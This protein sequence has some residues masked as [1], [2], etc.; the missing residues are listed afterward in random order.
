MI[1]DPQSTRP[2]SEQHAIGARDALYVL[3]AKDGRIKIGRSHCPSRRR[4]E[5]ECAS[6]LRL[7]LVA[8]FPVVGHFEKF[9]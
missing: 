4:R 8:E 2:Y 3:Q 6:G 9:P 7:R 1:D 5:I